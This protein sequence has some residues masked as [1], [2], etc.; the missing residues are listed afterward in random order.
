MNNY[1][2]T[3]NAMQPTPGRRTIKFSMT[4]TSIPAATRALASGG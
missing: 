3:N 1:W 2:I 4:Q